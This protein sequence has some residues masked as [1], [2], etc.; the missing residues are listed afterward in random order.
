MTQ[1]WKVM[2]SCAWLVRLRACP[3]LVP[4]RLRHAL[5]GPGKHCSLGHGLL[6]QLTHPPVMDMWGAA[7]HMSFRPTL[8]PAAKWRDWEEG[9]GRGDGGSA[10]RRVRQ[11]QEQSAVCG[12]DA[13]HCDACLGREHQGDT[14]QTTPTAL[15]TKGAS[16]TTAQRDTH[17]PPPPPPPPSPSSSPPP[18][19][20]LHLDYGPKPTIPQRLVL[21]SPE[22]L[23][24][25]MQLMRL[26]RPIGSWLLFWPCG[27]S[28]AL[29]AAPGCLPDPWLITLF[30]VG[31]LVMRGAGCTINDM[32]DKD[33]DSRVSMCVW[34]WVS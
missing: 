12:G 15:Q 33:Y 27:W 10:V 14:T 25:Y 28:L 29:S 22:T 5:T 8:T 20:P 31:A 16:M 32:W 30:G 23:A 3:S 26:D 1:G 2:Y 4:R 24:A 11:G 19:P 6:E 18:P 7:R 17:Y 21:S 13:P 9:E 34:L